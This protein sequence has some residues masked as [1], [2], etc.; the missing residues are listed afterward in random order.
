ME[1]ETRSAGSALA[2]ARNGVGRVP[3]VWAV[4]LGESEW[5]CQ[6]VRSCALGRLLRASL[7]DRRA[8]PP[9]FAR[10]LTGWRLSEQEPTLVGSCVMSLAPLGGP[11]RTKRRAAAGGAGVRVPAR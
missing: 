9:P 6:G 7:A 5:D 8:A 4:G 3:V 11:A 1:P 10:E 2:S